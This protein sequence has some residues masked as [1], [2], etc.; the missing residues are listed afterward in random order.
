MYYQNGH[1][2][3]YMIIYKEIGFQ[4]DNLRSPLTGRPLSA[5]YQKY[6]ISLGYTAIHYR[7]RTGPEQ[8]F[9]CVVFPHREKAVFISWDPCNENRF[10]PVA[11]ESIV[12]ARV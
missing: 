11:T 10:F 6:F 12:C 2:L 7:A 9:P 1:L 5:I 8:G 3:E 4:S